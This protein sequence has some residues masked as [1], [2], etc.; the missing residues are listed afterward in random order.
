ME[1]KE[2][3]F[4]CER[5]AICR[6]HVVP[7]T[8]EGISTIP[9]CGFCHSKI[10]GNCGFVYDKR[11]TVFG[12]AP[13]GYRT[14]NDQRVLNECER[15][16]ISIMSSL[17]KIYYSCE[18]IASTLNKRNYKTRDHAKWSS[19]YVE[20]ILR[21]EGIYDE[22][23]SIKKPNRTIQRN[24]SLALSWE[25]NPFYCEERGIC[26]DCGRRAVHNHHVV[27]KT[28]GGI[29]TVPLCEVCHDKAH[30]SGGGLIDS[31]FIK[32][33]RKKEGKADGTVSFGYRIVNGWKVEFEDE[34]STISM[35]SMLH[36]RNYSCREIAE[37]LN[38]RGFETRS[39]T[40][41]GHRAEWNAE[42]VRT[43]LKRE[44]VYDPKMDRH[45]NAQNVPYGY[46]VVHGKEVSLKGEQEVVEA[47]T[48]LRKKGC[49]RK[50]IVW[51]LNR[52][53]YERRGRAWSMETV[54]ILF[55]NLGCKRGAGNPP[56]G[57]TWG[58]EKFISVESEQEIIG[59]VKDMFERGFTKNEVA[60]KL[61]KS[62]CRTRKNQLWTGASVISSV[63]RIGRSKRKGMKCGK[64]EAPFGYVYVHKDSKREE[65]PV[66]AEQKALRLIKNLYANGYGCGRIIKELNKQGITNR[67]GNVWKEKRSIRHIVRRNEF[68]KGH[69][70]RRGFFAL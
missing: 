43:V 10:H 31:H 20:A 63:V 66:V 1:Q 53:G 21:R 33:R 65:I 32:E 15:D 52:R 56:Y 50:E 12:R 68:V 9:L 25:E 38:R 18:E 37:N 40:R 24:R 64:L 27:P 16:I 59:I 28:L 30:G 8:F 7:R 70:K 6:H 54:S 67:I 14:E 57:Y 55:E 34:Q 47:I 69:A 46:E 49:S 5:P 17:Y 58:L 4:E 61:N 36:E 22:N 11:E 29:R 42:Q 45:V 44:G 19:D 26:F 13:F 62:G 60:D 48:L 39:K 3:C 2:G 41:G 23:M 35:M 51:E